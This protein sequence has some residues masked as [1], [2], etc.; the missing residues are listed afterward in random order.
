MLGSLFHI[1]YI[2]KS[3]LNQILSIPIC[4]FNEK[5]AST[6][7]EQSSPLRNIPHVIRSGAQRAP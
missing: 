1:Y 3:A 2:I 4:L 7:G 6:H 5:V